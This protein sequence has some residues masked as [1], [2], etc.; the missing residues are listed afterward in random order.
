ML[1]WRWKR[2]NAKWSPKKAAKKKSRMKSK[3]SKGRARH[4]MP[5][6]WPTCA[7]LKSRPL[8]GTWWYNAFFET[9]SPC[10][11]KCWVYLSILL[12]VQL[13]IYMCPSLFSFCSPLLCIVYRAPLKCIS[14]SVCMGGASKTCPPLN[15]KGD[16]GRGRAD[17][18]RTKLWPTSYCSTPHFWRPRFNAFPPPQ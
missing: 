10:L 11:D 9:G 18:D 15:C 4:R 16:T 2:L 17:C 12:P 1:I 14:L 13:H 5:L 6:Q 3:K 7:I 8:L